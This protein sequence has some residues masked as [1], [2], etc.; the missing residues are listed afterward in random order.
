VLLT[1]G[2]ESKR[3]KLLDMFS[4]EN[5]IEFF[6]LWPLE[7]WISSLIGLVILYWFTGRLYNKWLAKYG[8]WLSWRTRIVL[9]LSD[10]GLNGFIGLYSL[11]F[12]KETAF[13]AFM[14]KCPIAISPAIFG[15]ELVVVFSLQCY[16]WWKGKNKEKLDKE[17]AKKNKSI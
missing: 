15:I 7:Q 8:G 3:G 4:K 17:Q 2:N 6:N 9:I 10:L 16:R 13:G 14:M 11:K 5:V 1:I 12:L